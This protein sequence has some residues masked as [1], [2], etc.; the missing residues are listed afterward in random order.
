MTRDEFLNELSSRLS[1]ISPAE[2]E[3]VLNYYLEYFEERGVA[4]G[5]PVPIDLATPAQIAD[6][7][8]R[9]IPFTQTQTGAGTRKH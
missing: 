6:E 8:L 1:R 9:D 3:N 7:I 5:S 4:A 2:R